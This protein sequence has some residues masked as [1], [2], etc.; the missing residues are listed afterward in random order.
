MFSVYALYNS[1]RNKIYIGHTDN[2]DKRIARHNQKLPT[3]ATSYTKKLSGTWVLV[4]DEPAANRAAA[5]LREKQLKSARG[6]EFVWDI[7]RKSSN[8]N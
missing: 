5:K 3:K 1:E 7:I 8:R 2:V 4:Y 6:R